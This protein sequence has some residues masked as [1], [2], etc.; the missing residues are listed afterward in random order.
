MKSNVKF[1]EINQNFTAKFNSSEKKH[2][3]AGFSETTVVTEYVGGEPYEGE[4]EITPKLQTQTL[5]TAQKTMTNNLIIKEIPFSE[6]GNTSGGTT[7]CI[8]MPDE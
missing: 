1:S 5:P 6:V 8:G 7:V 2:F 4:Y 3:Q